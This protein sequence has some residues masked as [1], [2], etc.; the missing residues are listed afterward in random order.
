MATR[1][2]A[3]TAALLAAAVAVSP[4][5]ALTAHARCIAEHH[6][7]DFTPSAADC[8]CRHVGTGRQA[9]ATAAGTSP[10]TSLP[11]AALSSTEWP[12]LAA[13]FTL[14]AFLPHGTPLPIDRVTLFRSLLI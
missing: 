12:A 4:I 14:P 5:G 9:P 6:A 10:E 3:W 8:C 1:I 2:S 11:P 7:C 13:S